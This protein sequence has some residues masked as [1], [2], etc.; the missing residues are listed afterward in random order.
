MYLT[1]LKNTVWC[2]IKGKEN[3]DQ[4]ISDNTINECDRK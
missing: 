1:T 4:N 3:N 2:F